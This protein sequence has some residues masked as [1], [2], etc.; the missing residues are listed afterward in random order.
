MSMGE[1]SK[2]STVQ[3]SEKLKKKAEAYTEFDFTVPVSQKPLAIDS[4]KEEILKLLEKKNIIVI[5]GFTGCG[6][7]TRIPQFVLDHCHST[8]TPC[9]IVVTQPRRL[10][11]ISVARRVCYERNWPLG[12][13]VGY[14]VNSNHINSCNH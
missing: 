13:V 12:S 2:I 4:R 10:A 6:K 1:N 7:T 9:N 5:K 14:K 11:A 3:I 8:K